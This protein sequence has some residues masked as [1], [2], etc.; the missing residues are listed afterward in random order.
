MNA[1]KWMGDHVSPSFTTLFIQGMIYGKEAEPPLIDQ[2]NALPLSG[3]WYEE[4]PLRVR[5]R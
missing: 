1:L 5:D 3:Y 2:I 4:L